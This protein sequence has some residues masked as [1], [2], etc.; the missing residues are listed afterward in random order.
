[1]DAEVWLSAYDNATNDPQEVA[2]LKTGEPNEIQRLQQQAEKGLTLQGATALEDKLQ[3]G[4]PEVLQDLRQAG[5]KI[6][7]LTGDKVGVC[8][9]L[10][11]QALQAPSLRR[12]G[13]RCFL[14]SVIGHLCGI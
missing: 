6:W 7:M 12:G 4:V 2:R 13:L 9:A 11:L 1:M 14:Q 10:T 8:V 3:D 5:V